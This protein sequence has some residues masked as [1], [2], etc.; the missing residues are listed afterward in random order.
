[1]EQIHD[2]L[3]VREIALLDGPVI[4]QAIRHEGPA[5]GAVEGACVRLPGHHR[6]ERPTLRHARHAGPHLPLGSPRLVLDAAHGRLGLRVVVRRG[7]VPPAYPLV[8]A[9]LPSHLLDQPLDP[10]RLEEARRRLRLRVFLVLDTRERRQAGDLVLLVLGLVDPA[11]RPGRPRPQPA[12]IDFDDHRRRG[13][14][15]TGRQLAAAPLLGLGIATP[16]QVSADFGGQLLHVAGRNRQAGQP[17]GEGGIGK[18]GEA[19]GGGNDLF[20]DGRGVA[21]AVK[22]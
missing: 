7:R 6:P 2:R 13:L 17:H 10:T 18:G 9:R 12:A 19:C 15:H 21:V 4:G 3:E 20:E 22:A 5:A 1:M 16:R 11:A 14:A 8:T